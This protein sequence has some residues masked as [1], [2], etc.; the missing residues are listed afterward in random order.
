MV[1]PDSP[2]WLRLLQICR[3]AKT[4]DDL[5]GELRTGPVNSTGWHVFPDAERFANS[6][7]LDDLELTRGPISNALERLAA[8]GDVDARWILDLP[9]E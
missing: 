9:A 7:K 1:H 5:L 6:R 4:V 2:D 3:E 8:S